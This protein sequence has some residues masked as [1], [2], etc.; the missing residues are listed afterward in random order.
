LNFAS[1]FEFGDAAQI[2]AQDPCFDL[3]LMLVGGVLVLAPAAAA[4]VRT[5]RRDSVRRRLD[6]CRGVRTGEAGLF[7]GDGGFDFFPREHEGH[8]YGLAA[9][10]VVG[11]EASESVAAVDELFNV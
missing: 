5:R 11:W 3:E 1:K 7:F 8:E 10:A 2:L 4:E 9:S 6:D